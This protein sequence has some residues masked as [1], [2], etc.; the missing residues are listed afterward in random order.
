[1]VSQ[2]RVVYNHG[3]WHFSYYSD[4]DNIAEYVGGDKF[5]M[6]KLVKAM[7]VSFPR[8]QKLGGVIRLPKMLPVLQSIEN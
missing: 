5:R 6:Q 4:Y 8:R 7:P 2:K 3:N 1:V